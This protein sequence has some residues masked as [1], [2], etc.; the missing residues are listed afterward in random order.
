MAPL[1]LR[2]TP[3][4]SPNRSKTL[5]PATSMS[6]R[7]TAPSSRLLSFLKNESK[8]SDYGF[9]SLRIKQKEITQTISHIH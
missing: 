1:T 4:K 5:S 8:D 6:S 9:N 7:V 3:K 2:P